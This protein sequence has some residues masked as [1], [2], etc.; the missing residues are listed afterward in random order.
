MLAYF[1]RLYT[2]VHSLTLSTI[3]LLLPLHAPCGATCIADRAFVRS[4]R[5]VH[6]V[7]VCVTPEGFRHNGGALAGSQVSAVVARC[8]VRIVCLLVVGRSH[9]A[10]AGWG[11]VGGWG[12]G[13]KVVVVGGYCCAINCFLLNNGG[14][15]VRS[16]VSLVIAALVSSGWGGGSATHIPTFDPSTR[17]LITITCP[18]LSVHPLL[19]PAPLDPVLSMRSSQSYSSTSPL[20]F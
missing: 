14:D 8:I 20:R 13:E 10:G 9:Q 15:L 7:C 18:I 12:G 3:V 5:C 19:S 6:L 1:Q 11:W 2:A 4:S 16:Q 17:L